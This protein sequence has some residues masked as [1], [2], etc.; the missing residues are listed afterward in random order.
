[1]RIMLVYAACLLGILGSNAHAASVSK[2]YHYYKIGGSSLEE[3]EKELEVRGPE[4]ETTGLRH[5]GATRMEFTT[6]VT[7]GQQG[8]RCRVVEASVHV[9]AEMI[10]PLWNRRNRSDQETRLIWDTL[11]ADIKRHEEAHITIAKNHA[12]EIEQALMLINNQHD[13]DSAQIKAQQTADR[14]LEKH[15]REQTRFDRIESTNF[16]SRLL[17]LL[18]YRLE[19]TDLAR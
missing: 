18:R 12:R 9:D 16:E 10:L 6:R 1:M 7:Y 8:R 2:V 15:D 3:I 17:R 19:R 5:P 13:C 14:I 4:L 11:S